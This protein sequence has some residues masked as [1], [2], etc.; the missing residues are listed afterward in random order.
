MNIVR[1]NTI[2][3]G[4]AV[5]KKS[6]GSAI[7]NV[8]LAEKITYNELVALRDAGNLVAGKM[9][10][11]TD[12]DTACG[13][14]DVQ[15]AGHPFDLVLMALDNKTL[16]EK[17]SAIWSERDTDGYFADSN[18]PAWDVRYCLDNDINR[19]ESALV[20]GHIMQVSDYG[21]SIECVPCGKK[22]IDGVTYYVW[23]GNSFYALS[24]T[25]TPEVGSRVPTVV[26]SSWTIHGDGY[27]E[28]TY[29]RDG[30][31]GV[32]YRLTDENNN[33]IH[34]D[35]KNFMFKRRVNNGK[36]D[37]DNGVETLCYT[38]SRIES[39]GSISD[40]SLKYNTSCC[41][42]NIGAESLDNVFFGTCFSNIIGRVCCR[43]TFCDSFRINTLGDY[44][45]DNV[46]YDSCVD[47]K[48]GP[49]FTYNTAYLLS[50]NNIC[51]GCRKATFPRKFTD[52][53]ITALGFEFVSFSYDGNE[54][55]D[56]FKHHY[57]SGEPYRKQ[58]TLHGGR[59]YPTYITTDKNGNVIE[60]TSDTIIEKI[61]ELLNTS[62]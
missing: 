23:K 53:V 9:Y 49:W 12:Y 27:V 48:L 31:T 38:F 19:F 45:Y 58:I 43:N 52:N 22:T 20:G 62:V 5:I 17:C 8:E 21:I 3:G 32:I 14:E 29:T 16:D 13:L 2:T 60:Y 41:D 61:A 33:V 10:R 50:N 6:G 7:K 56:F 18:L 37:K 42:N 44:T 15:C 24:E 28:S 51:E 40:Y 47:N 30:G 57:I 36:Y 39:N 11:M 46:F 26:D 34:Y 55:T 54:E 25:P 4:G 35:F 1:L 59:T